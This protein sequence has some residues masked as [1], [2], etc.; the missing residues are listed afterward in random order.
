MCRDGAGGT[1]CSNMFCN[2][3]LVLQS[4]NSGNPIVLFCLSPLLVDDKD[5]CIEMF[6]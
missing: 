3:F 5:T 2:T 1:A 4:H 6:P